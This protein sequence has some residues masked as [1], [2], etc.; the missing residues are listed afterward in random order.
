MN[1]TF[2]LTVKTEVK[3]TLTILPQQYHISECGTF[4]KRNSFKMENVIEKKLDRFSKYYGG[5][6]FT[7]SN[8][9]EFL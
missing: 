1:A 2:I 7:H 9:I 8:V 3:S 6:E 4:L 5:S